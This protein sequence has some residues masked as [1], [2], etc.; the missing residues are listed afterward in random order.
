ME[1]SATALAGLQ[2]SHW[3]DSL[4]YRR[5]ELLF[6]LRE[7][8]DKESLLKKQENDRSFLSFLIFLCGLKASSSMNTRKEKKVGTSL[9]HLLI[10]SSEAIFLSEENW[11]ALNFLF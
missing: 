6:L 3:I 2:G 8:P 5:F 4:S 9:D 10:N 7:P 1:S 11:E